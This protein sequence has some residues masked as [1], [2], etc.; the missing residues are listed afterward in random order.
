VSRAGGRAVIYVR[1]SS[2]L[3]DRRS[4]EDQIAANEEYAR[5]MGLTV[6]LPPFRDDAISGAS[7]HNHYCPANLAE[8][9]I[10]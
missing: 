7:V 10:G 2:D 6:V 4:N 3:Q 1:F 9:S 5:R 8:V